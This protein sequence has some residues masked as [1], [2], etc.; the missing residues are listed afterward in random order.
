MITGGETSGS[1]LGLEIFSWVASHPG[2][3]AHTGQPLGVDRDGAADH[4]GSVQKA[5]ISNQ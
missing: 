3:G 1:Q 5:L 2:E 4:T